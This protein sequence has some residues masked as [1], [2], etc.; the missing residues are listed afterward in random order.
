MGPF[1]P[2]GAQDPGG[3]AGAMPIGGV[4]VPAVRSRVLGRCLALRPGPIRSIFNVDRHS[5]T[6]LSSRPPPGPG[7]A[8][9]DVT[10]TA[11][12][13]ATTSEGAPTQRSAAGVRA[14]HYAASAGTRAWR[15]AA[16]T[17]LDA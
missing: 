11:P 12:E 6:T 16:G 2:D 10:S 7:S 13:P 4:L 1:P 17:P 14:F 9:A 15:R 3:W 5:S 8:G